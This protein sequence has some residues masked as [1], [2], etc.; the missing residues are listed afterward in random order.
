MS[1][2]GAFV[3]HVIAKD[4][5]LSLALIARLPIGG[6]ALG[7]ASC[8]VH[9]IG[10]ENAWVCPFNDI[11][12][13][14]GPLGVRVW[15]GAVADGELLTGED[16]GPAPLPEQALNVVAQTITASRAQRFVTADRLSARG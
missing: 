8:A 5:V 12:V 16:V 1:G 13:G 10:P 6:V 15:T 3:N 11:F 14:S 9:L 4:A 2:E 7:L